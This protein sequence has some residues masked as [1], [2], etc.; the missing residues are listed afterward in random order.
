MKWVRHELTLIELLVVIVLI[1]IL[2]GMCP[3]SLNFDRERARRVQC[4]NN[5]KQI[6][7]ACKMYSNEYQDRFP[8]AVPGLA[9]PAAACTKAETGKDFQLLADTQFLQW[10]DVYICRSSK[11]NDKM[12]VTGTGALAAGEQS[13]YI[14]HGRGQ[15]ENTIGTETVLARDWGAKVG[16]ATDE[17]RTANH[18]PKYM[19]LLFGDGHTEARNKPTGDLSVGSSGADVRINEQTAPPAVKK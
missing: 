8:S 12:P 1:A 13:S 18:D 14:Y 5:L 7:T 17:S 3:C 6:G 10:G 4:M 19:N 2:A 15:T 16:A 9:L 11:N